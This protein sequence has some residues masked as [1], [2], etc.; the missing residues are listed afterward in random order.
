VHPV[1]AGHG[2]RQPP[3]RAVEVAST[4]RA[5]EA[6]ETPVPGPRPEV[7]HPCP[8]VA[9]RRR[10]PSRHAAWIPPPM[11]RTFVARTWAPGDASGARPG[12]RGVPSPAQG[13]RTVAA[14][15]QRR[16]GRVGR[17]RRRGDGGPRR[18]QRLGGRP[19]K[20]RRAG[21]GRGGQ[22]SC[23]QPRSLARSHGVGPQ[24]PGPRGP[25]G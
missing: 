14:H 7:P 5:S 25:E 17:H 21:S 2:D 13:P 8:A 3:R 23:R 19:I 16:R 9:G 12:G 20:G 4:D 18:R 15:R 6:V 11:R 22:W 1:V 10:G 24:G